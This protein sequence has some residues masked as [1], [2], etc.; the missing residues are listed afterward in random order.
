MKKG[1][2]TGDAPWTNHLWQLRKLE[3]HCRQKAR[4][5]WPRSGGWRGRCRAATRIYSQLIHSPVWASMGQ[6]VG[7]LWTSGA[8]AL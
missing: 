2:V 7:T 3:L 6:L 4:Q 1:R 8:S 5:V